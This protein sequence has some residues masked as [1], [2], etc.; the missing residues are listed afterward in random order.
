MIILSSDSVILGNKI[1]WNEC[2]S[3]IA[4]DFLE[5]RAENTLT[6][7]GWRD[8]GSDLQEFSS[9]VVAIDGL[10]DLIELG[11]GIVTESE[12]HT[13]RK[14]LIRGCSLL[15]HLQDKAKE[16]GL[17]EGA[18]LHED[19]QDHVVTG[20]VAK[21]AMI[22]ARTSRIL[23]ESYPD[24]A[25]EYLQRAI[26]AFQWIAKNGPI[27]NEEEQKFYAPVHGAPDGTMPPEDQWMTRRN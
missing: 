4:F 13:I 3:T 21:A 17:G 18:V 24:L 8:S 27:V 25:Q 20:N 26:K 11:E 2:Y 5:A 16:M 7:K 1:L 12:K 23:R 19:R 14:H 10:C 9:H 6:G 22:F 15:V